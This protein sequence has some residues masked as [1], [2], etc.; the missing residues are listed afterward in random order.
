MK[1]IYTLVFIIIVSVV[2]NISFYTSNIIDISTGE[3]LN[4][5]VLQ[6]PILRLFIEP[7]YAFAYYIL[8]MERSGYVFALISWLSWLVLISI[9]LCRYKYF[10][11]KNTII[12]CCFSF[13]FFISLCCI[14]VILPIIGP[15]ITNI[16]GYK[17]I[18]IHSH[19][20]SSRDNISSVKSSINFHKKHGFTDFFITE[21][22]NTN[23]YKTIPNSLETEHIFPGI[24]I[25]TK[26]GVSVLLLSKNYF[27]YEDFK[28][29]NIK[30]LIDLAHSQDMLVIM[31]HW[32]KWNRPNLQQ[33]IDWGIDGFEIYNCGYRYIS[34]QT[35]QKLIDICNEKNLSMFGT[36]DWHGLGY[37]TNVWTLIENKNDKTVFELIKDKT[38][39][40]IVVHDVKGNQSV[41]RYVF[42]P[43]Y[44]I[45]LYV[46]TTQ[47]KYVVSFYMFILV[48]IGLLYNIPVM[49]VI[50]IVSLLLACFFSTCVFYFV[51]MLEYSF[52]NNVMIPETIIPTA[53]SLI[54]IWIV[55]WGFCDKNI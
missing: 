32:W 47:L 7:F 5:I 34:D 10:K 46:T 24:Q 52:C 33:L 6:W 28:D 14:V 1:K 49:R 4:N 9:L 25:R 29:K 31:P 30:E 13:F 50:R 20:I 18:D 21:H 53:L 22:D 40:K 44:F 23:G 35:R 11:L 8:T 2:L 17:S 43:F 26:D 48:L 37:M 55:I 39:T 12:F 51:Y 41:L 19:T 16:N 15:K 27:E 3:Q 45:F 38:K 36:T 42:E 54:F